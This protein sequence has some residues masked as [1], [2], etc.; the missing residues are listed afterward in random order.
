MTVN[1]LRA[2]NPSQAVIDIV[3]ADA[4]E[5]DAVVVLTQSAGFAPPAGR[6]ALVEALSDLE[7][8]VIEVAVRNPY[9][10][11]STAETEAAIA[12][13]GY[14][15]VSLH[16]IANVITGDINPSGTLPVAIPEADGTGEVYPLGHGLSYPVPD[17]VEAT[18]QLAASVQDYVAAGEVD[19]PIA[20]QLANAVDQAEQHLEGERTTPAI[21][22]LERVLRHL[23]NPKRPDT[24]TEEAQ[25]DLRGQVTAILD[26]IG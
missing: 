9:D 23:D 5:R 11:V 1:M 20:H 12:S 14:A 13:Y 24:L 2:N 25:Q 4:A 22:A 8:D 18:T 3:A 15:P 21:A 7:T 19:G 6:L 16:A 26:L 17:P 10:T